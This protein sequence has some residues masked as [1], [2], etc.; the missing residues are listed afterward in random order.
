MEPAGSSEDDSRRTAAFSRERQRRLR[1]RTSGGGTFRWPATDHR[2]GASRSGPSCDNPRDVSR[3]SVARSGALA[4]PA[5]R[6]PGR[7]PGARPPA[8]RR[9]LDVAEPRSPR[10]PSAPTATPGPGDRLRPDRGAGPGDPRAQG[11]DAGRADAASDDAALKQNMATSFAKDN[12]PER[13]RGD[14]APVRAH[15]SRP[16][17]HRHWPTSTSSCSAA[18]SPALRPRR[19][20]SCTS[21]RSRAVVGSI[22]KFVFAHEY[23]HALQDQHFDLDEPGSTSRSARAMRS[24]AAPGARRGRRDPAD[25]PLGAA[26][27]V[28][29]RAARHGHRVERP[30]RSRRSSTRCRRSCEQTLLFPYTAGA[31]ASCSSAKPAGGLAG[32]RRACRQA[33]GLDRAD[34][35]PREVRR[36]ARRRSRSSFPTTS[37]RG[38]GRLDGRARGHA[39]RAP[40]R[41]LARE[42]AGKVPTAAATA[43]AA[44]W[45]GDRVALV[46]NGPTRR[47]RRHRT[48]PLGHAGGRGG[49]RGRGAD[50]A[51]RD[52][53]RRT[54]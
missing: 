19:P 1:K 37:R 23:D 44:G 16:G 9:R 28:A 4:R 11:Q 5:R 14:R 32:G 6:G 52:R 51:R 40:A 46:S 48:R 50:R 42:S 13:H 24:L 30:G 10:R 45:G 2:A 39:R 31:A 18:R 27:D 47:G 20:R 25:V 15:G 38:S 35:P 22:E 3:S 54:P 29:G 36:P 26:G 53:R 12:P 49:V 34:P 8:P 33:A 43:A 21:S 7:V 17:R 41:R